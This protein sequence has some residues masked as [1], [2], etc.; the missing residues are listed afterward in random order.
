[1]ARPFKHPK[2]GIYWFRKR[3]PNTLR[4]HVG[5]LEE[6]VSLSDTRPPD[7]KDRTRSRGGSGRAS[8]AKTSRRRTV[9]F[10]STGGGY[11]GRNLP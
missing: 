3:V 11:R 4:E 2:T 1:M 7:C 8:L 5:K 6:K 9:S 10:T